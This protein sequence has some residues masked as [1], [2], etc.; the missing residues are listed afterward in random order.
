MRI[1]RVYAHSQ[2]G[3]AYDFPW[4][5]WINSGSWI[6]SRIE[7]P[8]CINFSGECYSQCEYWGRWA[9]RPDSM[10]FNNQR[11]TLGYHGWIADSPAPIIDR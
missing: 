10:R 6:T 7:G 9:D 11:S 4:K 1:L 2:G 8:N 5:V 3:T